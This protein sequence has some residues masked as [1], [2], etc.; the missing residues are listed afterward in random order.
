[1]A[2]KSTYYMLKRIHLEPWYCPDGCNRNQIDYY[3]I[4]VKARKDVNIDLVHIIKLRPRPKRAS[5]TLAETYRS[6]A[7]N[8]RRKLAGVS[9]PKPLSLDEKWKRM[10]EGSSLESNDK[11]HWL[12]TKTR[13]KEVVRRDERE[14]ECF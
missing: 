10:E 3:V 7:F 9:E 12:H 4:D 13:R 8:E 5:N 2:I 14:E 6:Q 1:M 11:Q